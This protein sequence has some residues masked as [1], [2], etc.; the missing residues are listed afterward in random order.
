MLCRESKFLDSWQDKANRNSMVRR[1][2]VNWKGDLVFVI[3][4]YDS[5]ILGIYDTY[6]EAINDC[7][8]D[9]YDEEFGALFV[10]LYS[11]D[12][13]EEWRHF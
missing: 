5:D 1:H 2:I 8:E 3:E 13:T 10:S 4:N 9:Y 11:F 7:P 12:S 6:E